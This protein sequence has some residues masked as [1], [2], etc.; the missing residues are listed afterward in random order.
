MELAM[1]QVKRRLAEA[2][3]GAVG[4]LPAAEG[5]AFGLWPFEGGVGFCSSEARA[6]NPGG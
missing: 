6:Q 2:P 1:N 4:P 3:G 5:T